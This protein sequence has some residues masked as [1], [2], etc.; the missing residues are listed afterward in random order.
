MTFPHIELAGT[1]SGQIALPTVVYHG[2]L[3][4]YIPGYRSRVL[5]SSYWR[6]RDRD[7]G[8]GFYTTISFNQAADWALKAEEKSAEVGAF[9]EVGSILKIRILPEAYP[10][11]NNCLVFLSESNVHWTRFIVDHRLECREDGF[12]PCGSGNHPAIIIGQ[13]ADNKMDTVYKKFSKIQHTIDDKYEW[14]FSEITQN[15]HGS[16]LDS[17]QLGN[18]ITFCDPGMNELLQAESYFVFDQRRKEWIE[19]DLADA[20]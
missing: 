10:E 2:T 6:K 18:Q 4:R 5:D 17:L 9:D 8:P 1:F 11:F 19:H 7:F 3:L 12:D 14:F 13:M 15:K 16:S 20:K